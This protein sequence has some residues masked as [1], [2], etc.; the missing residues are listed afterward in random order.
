[1]KGLILSGGR[2]TRLRPIT[3]T[4]AKQL[5]PVA[6]KPIL[7]YGIEALAASGISEIGIVVGDTK[8]EIRDA[9]GDGSRFGVSVTYIEQEAPLGLAHAV[10]VSEP[11]LGT[12]PFC[13]YLGDNL[14]RERLAPLVTRFRD[15]K[16]NCQILLAAVPDPT[17]F[18][19]A[20][21][22]D[23]QVVRLVEKPKE[24]PSNLALVGVYMFDTNIF[25]AVKAIKPSWRNE[26]EITDAIQWLVDEDQGHVVRPHVVEGWWKDPASSRTCSRPTDHSRTLLP[27]TD[28]PVVD[29][30]IVGRV[31]IEAGGA[32]D[33]E[34]VARARRSSAATAVIESAYVGPSRR[35]R[36]RGAPGQRSRAI[37]PSGSASV[38]DRG[39]PHRN[40]ASSAATCPSTGRVQARSFT[41]HAGDLSEVGLI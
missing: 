35:S 34:H 41:L 7:F 8:Q 32:R 23:G 14:I 19:V 40:R 27:R 38:T 4:S 17:Q 31:V 33:Q 12:D 22:K 30:E 37:D 29:S 15:E 21:L 6:N 36:S 16:P 13:M 18:G 2:G 9:V 25:D 26:L 28:G 3:F 11:F 39:R 5:V 24:P 1:M 20:V 10:L